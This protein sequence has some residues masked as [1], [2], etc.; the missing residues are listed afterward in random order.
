MEVCVCKV[1][2]SIRILVLQC[3]VFVVSFSCVDRAGF[4]T[5]HVSMQSE[6][7]YLLLAS[8][9]LHSLQLTSVTRLKDNEIQILLFEQ[10][11]PTA[12]SLYV[13]NRP[14]TVTKHC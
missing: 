11:V 2:A 10:P 6:Q 4:L 7:M 1:L 5:R 12:Q 13:I 9:C 3:Y 14:T 8:F